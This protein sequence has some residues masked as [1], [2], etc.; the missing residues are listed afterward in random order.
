M[1]VR[2]PQQP[3]L[4]CV[5]LMPGERQVAGGPWCGLLGGALVSRSPMGSTAGA[6]IFPPLPAPPVPHV[7]PPAP[8]LSPAL[9]PVPRSPGLS[10]PLWTDSSPQLCHCLVVPVWERGGRRLIV[11]MRP[12]SCGV[13]GAFGFVC[14]CDFQ[15]V[16]SRLSFVL[17]L[18]TGPRSRT[19]FKGL[20][21]DDTVLLLVLEPVA[22][23][24]SIID[25]TVHPLKMPPRRLFAWLSHSGPMRPLFALEPHLQD[26]GSCRAGPVGPNCSVLPPAVC[27]Y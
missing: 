11:P 8:P 20:S 15:T 26:P 18:E 22:V 19:F 24:I 25:A 9:L 6:G 17:L 7:V 13:A 3:R 14:L 21:C 27:T 1:P 23:L 2:P 4:I 10:G 12:W 5:E 16:A